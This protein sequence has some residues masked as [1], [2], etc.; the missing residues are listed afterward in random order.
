MNNDLRKLAK[1]YANEK[2]LKLEDVLDVINVP[3][4]FFA[5]IMKT[6]CDREKIYFPSVRIPY[7]GIY[8]SPD[9]MRKRFKKKK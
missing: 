7:W 6:K 4:D 3:F 8:Y 2:G 1:I 5:H 9:W